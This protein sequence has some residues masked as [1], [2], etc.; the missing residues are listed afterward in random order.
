MT[1]RSAWTIV[2]LLAAGCSSTPATLLSTAPPAAESIGAGVVRVA[3]PQ[4][5]SSCGTPDACTLVKA[6]E[7]AKKAGGT[8][9]IV[10]PGHGGAT[11]AGHAYIKVFTADAGDRL[12]SGALSVEEVLQFMAKPSPQL[13]AG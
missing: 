4:D 2:C 5:L 6:A 9:F 3:L 11:Q 1:L 10:L 13:V 12:P 8:H 7:A